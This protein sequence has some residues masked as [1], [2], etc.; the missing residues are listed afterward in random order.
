MDALKSPQL[1]IGNA[2]IERV[3]LKSNFIFSSSENSSDEK[4]SKV[5]AADTHFSV[6]AFARAISA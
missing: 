6:I 4:S 2:Q 3:L 5:Y 1:T